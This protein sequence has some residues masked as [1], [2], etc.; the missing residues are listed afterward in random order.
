M[1]NKDELRARATIE[2][3]WSNQSAEGPLEK[4]KSD[5]R[6]SPP[7]WNPPDELFND[8]S[9]VATGQNFS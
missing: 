3:L 1:K 2:P 5:G 8:I 9:H 7:D 4:I 6:Y